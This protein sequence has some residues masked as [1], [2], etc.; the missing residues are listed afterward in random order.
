MLSAEALGW[1]AGGFFIGFYAGA[2]A[3]ALLARH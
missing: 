3:M 1:L 2:L